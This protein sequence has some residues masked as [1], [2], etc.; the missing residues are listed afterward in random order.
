MT[1]LIFEKVMLTY[2]ELLEKEEIKKSIDSNKSVKDK[3]VDQY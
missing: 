1:H 3:D 2:K